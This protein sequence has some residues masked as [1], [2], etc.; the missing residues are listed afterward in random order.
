MLLNVLIMCCNYQ[1]IF[2]CLTFSELCNVINESKNE[3]ILKNL[4]MLYGIAQELCKYLFITVLKLE[5]LKIYDF[6]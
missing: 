1:L 4:N 5:L 3:V 2:R 6:V